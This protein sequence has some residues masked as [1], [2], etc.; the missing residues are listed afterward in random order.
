MCRALFG[1]TPGGEVEARG[2]LPDGAKLAIAGDLWGSS[3]FR[4]QEKLCQG[5]DVLKR[6][7]WLRASFGFVRSY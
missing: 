2:R 3:Q 7:R 5:L 4:L 6:L 1:L